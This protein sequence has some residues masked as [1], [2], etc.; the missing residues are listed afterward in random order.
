MASLSLTA[1]SNTLS[2]FGATT[3][4]NIIG[5]S[6]SYNVVVESGTNVISATQSDGNPRE[7]MVKALTVGEGVVK[8]V[9]LKTNEVQRFNV[10]VKASAAP[11]SETIT[12]NG[13]SFD[14]VAVE[15]GTFMMG[16]ADG[17]TE[18]DGDERPRHYV[19]LGG[20]SIGKTEV[21]QA[22]WEAVMGSNPSSFNGANRPVESVS[23]N[24]C[25]EFIKKL[26]GLT[27]RTFRLPTEAE[28]EFAARGGNLGKGCKYA[29]SDDLDAVAW[30]DG[31]SGGQTHDVA[32]KSPNELGLYDMSG[33]VWEWCQDW[34]GG[35]PS[36][37]QTDPQG[38]DTGSY[39]V[40]RGGGWN[41]IARYCRVSHRYCLNPDYRDQSYGL[42][43]A[44][45]VLP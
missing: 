8:V 19:T 20:F 34:Y 3:T 21:T 25:Q 35:Y 38:P 5:G 15:G 14:M 11:R 18:A 42:R 37:A 10:T 44:L 29:G 1:Y 32:T 26:N 27:G 22:L 40:N 31:N 4:F 41:Y 16:A 2:G 6:G 12:V 9:D 24:D 28:W 43:L 17:D 33:N 23:W 39:R 45:Q 30:Y 7:I 13:V 36:E